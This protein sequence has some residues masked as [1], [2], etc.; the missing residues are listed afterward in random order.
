MGYRVLYA[1][2]VFYLTCP[3][4]FY[5]CIGGSSVGGSNDRPNDYL[6]MNQSID[7]DNSDVTVKNIIHLSLAAG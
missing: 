6:D 1:Q 4:A 7:E 3:C 2:F 5:N